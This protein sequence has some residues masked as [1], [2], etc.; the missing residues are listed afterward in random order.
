M[1]SYRIIT[2]EWLELIDSLN[3]CRITNPLQRLPI[4][5]QPNI[6]H[7]VD[8]IQKF[9]KSLLMMWLSEPSSVIE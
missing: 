9:D 2:L 6:V 5:D 8:V 1:F 7:C 3:W 4:C